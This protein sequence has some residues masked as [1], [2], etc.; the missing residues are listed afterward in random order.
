MTG[1]YI[2]GHRTWYGRRHGATAQ[3][4]LG[5]TRESFQTMD[6]VTRLHLHF[7]ARLVGADERAARRR[8]ARD[9]RDLRRR[10]PPAR[11]AMT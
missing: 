6:I 7:K 2:T 8:R 3:G 4:R 1:A 10:R 9:A 11:R 5:A